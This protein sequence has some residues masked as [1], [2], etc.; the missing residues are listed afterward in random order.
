MEFNFNIPNRITLIRVLLI[1]LFA[2]VLLAD[3][4]YKNY[5]SAFIFL[6][7]SASD[8]FDGYL[9]RKKKQNTE[10]GVLIDPIADKLLISTALVI[11]IGKGVEEW[12]AFAIIFREVLLTL[13]RIYLIPMKISIPASNFG[14]S[15]TAV[16]SIAVAAALLDLGF[17][18]YPPLVK[19]MMIIAVFL[20][21]GSGV[22]YLVRIRKMTGN[23]IVNLPNVITLTRLLMVYP[24]AHYLL[25]GKTSIAMAFLAAITLGDKLDGISARMMNQMTDLGSF[26][27]SATDV[28]FIIVTSFLFVKIGY[29]TLSYTIALMVPAA[30]IGMIKVYKFVNKKTA[31]SSVIGKMAVGWAYVTGLAVFIDFAYKE[32]LLTA[33]LGMAYITLFMFVVRLRK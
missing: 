9:A 10:F 14:K 20:T 11:L 3:I 26:F 8:A 2:A 17:G 29:L 12:M 27:D 25:A 6:M 7:L 30:I 15:K 4:P 1:P 16:Q 28:I 24:F 13:V 32:V 31:S 5:F 18:W 33:G 19:I 22:E 23:K 21:L